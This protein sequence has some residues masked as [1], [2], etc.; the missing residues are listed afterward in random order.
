M[1]FFAAIDQPISNMEQRRKDALAEVEFY[2]EAVAIRLRRNAEAADAA[3]IEGKVVETEIR[4]TSE[5]TAADGTRAAAVGNTGT[6]VPNEAAIRAA[7]REQSGSRRRIR[8]SSDV[9]VVADDLVVMDLPVAA[10]IPVAAGDSPELRAATEPKALEPVA[11]VQSDRE[12]KP[13]A[14]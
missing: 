5:L 11:D 7:S 13:A 8:S 9:A 2:R 10:D 6:T 3:M 12:D 4:S 1:E 14:G